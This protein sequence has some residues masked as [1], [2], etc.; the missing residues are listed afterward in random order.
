MAIQVGFLLESAGD[1]TQ[2]P[3]EITMAN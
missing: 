2:A 3:V 1:G